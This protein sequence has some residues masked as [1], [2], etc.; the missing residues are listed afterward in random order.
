MKITVKNPGLFSKLLYIV[1]LIIIIPLYADTAEYFIDV[2]N[3]GTTDKLGIG[4]LLVN[5]YGIAVLLLFI[6]LECTLP[7]SLNKILKNDFRS[8]S[9]AVLN[10]CELITSASAALLML[11]FTALPSHPIWILTVMIGLSVFT[12]C[13]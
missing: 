13:F 5:F 1:Y 3:A 10:K 6:L 12:V 2:V 9:S 11:I 7:K 8:N 4:S